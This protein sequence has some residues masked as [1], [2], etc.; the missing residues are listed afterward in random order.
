MEKNII[1]I[2]EKFGNNDLLKSAHEA[3]FQLY[4]LEPSKNYPEES[5]CYTGK[6]I[7]EKKFS[8][9]I[10]NHQK[11]RLL[12]CA[13]VIIPV[14]LGKGYVF[15][16]HAFQLDLNQVEVEFNKLNFPGWREIREGIMYLLKDHY[17]AIADFLVDF[18]GEKDNYPE[19]AKSF[20]ELRRSAT[21]GR[22]GV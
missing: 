11:N 14:S 21:A 13:E 15:I 3:S 8:R 5:G 6:D 16:T 1:K 10:P 9:V 19:L 17:H 7:H 20:H 18:N 2:L 22:F 4:V 12:F